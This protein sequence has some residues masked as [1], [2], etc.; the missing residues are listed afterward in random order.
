MDS[1]YDNFEFRLPKR[2]FPGIHCAKAVSTLLLLLLLFHYPRISSLAHG[3]HPTIRAPLVLFPPFHTL[4]FSLF[5]LAP[6]CSNPS[7]FLFL[8]CISS[9]VDKFC[10][11]L[12]AQLHSSF[13][14]PLP[15]TVPFFVPCTS[16]T[17]TGSAP[18]FP[19]PVRIRTSHCLSSLF[20]VDTY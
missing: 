11:S 3:E 6:S 7:F 20:Y 19:P 15:F 18:L 10:D 14:C 12:R 1:L 8:R 9:C 17:P 4:S 5:Y 16:G 2:L 13:L